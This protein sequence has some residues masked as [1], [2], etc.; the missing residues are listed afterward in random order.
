MSTDKALSHTNN[1]FEVVQVIRR[2]I[3][4]ATLYPKKTQ[5]FTL[6]S[7]LILN[8][9]KLSK[10]NW[11][12][13][14]IVYLVI[15]KQGSPYHAGSHVIAKQIACFLPR[16]DRKNNKKSLFICSAHQYDHYIMM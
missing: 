5:Y 4:F 2:A 15:S 7:N 9:M 16:I 13:Y 8:L 1:L 3:P 11:L 14:S 12:S 10:K 6:T